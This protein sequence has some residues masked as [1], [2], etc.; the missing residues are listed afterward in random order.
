MIKLSF[1]GNYLVHAGAEDDVIE[2]TLDKLTYNSTI[3]GESGNDTIAVVGTPKDFNM[4]EPNTVAERAFDSI[5]TVE[6]LAFGTP[7]TLY[8]ISGTKTINLSSK[9]QLARSTIDA[10]HAS[11]LETMY[12]K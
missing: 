4:W 7:D 3:K 9:V 2:I 10:T 1:E 5:S 12:W 6:T 11:G 8:R